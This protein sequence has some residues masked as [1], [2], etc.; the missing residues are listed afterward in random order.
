MTGMEWEKV[1]HFREAAARKLKPLHRYPVVPDSRQMLL[2]RAPSSGSLL[3]VGANDRNVER[4]LKSRG[5]TLKYYSCDVDRSLPHDFYDLDEVTI[6]F[7]QSSLFDVIE[8]VSPEVAMDILK[9]IHGHLK[10]GGQ[11]FVTTP[12][13]D[14]PTRFWRDC[15]HITPFRFDELAGFLM[16]AGFEDIEIYRVA[17]LKWQDRLRRLWAGPMLRLLGADFAPT[18]LLIGVRKK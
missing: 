13:V 2:D 4:Y 5:A 16:A 15:T 18:I 11:L 10:P 8:H 6:N 7:D 9:K 17:R 3:D 14:H 12:N 1:K